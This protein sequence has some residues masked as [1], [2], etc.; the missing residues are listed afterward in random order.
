VG[1][2]PSWQI[3]RVRIRRARFAPPGQ[4]PQ[5]PQYRRL[6]P[7]LAVLGLPGRAD[8]R[9][10]ASRISASGPATG[11]SGHEA[12]FGK[13][14]VKLNSLVLC[15]GF[16]LSLFA[17][18]LCYGLQAMFLSGL[19]FLRIHMLQ[20]IVLSFSSICIRWPS[21]PRRVG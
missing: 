11:P 15:C 9:L 5:L 1:E 20:A 10:A 21:L 14:T 7:H 18:A 13:R 4:S 16:L 3:P 2:H 17:L 8:G 12:T 6:L 19:F